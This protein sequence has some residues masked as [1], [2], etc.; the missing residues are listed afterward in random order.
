MKL[1]RQHNSDSEKML[2]V[3]T[4]RRDIYLQVVQVGC[5]HRMQAV[6]MFI[7]DDVG[8]L[9]EFFAFVHVAS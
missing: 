2:Y 4:N 7:F 5:I 3:Q 9:Y 6:H 8:Q 1:P